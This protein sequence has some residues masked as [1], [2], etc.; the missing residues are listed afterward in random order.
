MFYLF[1]SFGYQSRSISSVLC[2]LSILGLNYV[3]SDDDIN[4]PRTNTYP[5]QFLTEV[6]IFLVLQ[7]VSSL[8]KKHPHF[9]H[10]DFSLSIRINFQHSLSK[11]IHNSFIYIVIGL[12]LFLLLEVLHT[13][14]RITI[15][16]S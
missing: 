2:M 9:S 6:L 12:P 16:L 8:Q 5:L 15:G 11:Q 13:T 3:E 7:L 14:L 4:S 10:N 1:H